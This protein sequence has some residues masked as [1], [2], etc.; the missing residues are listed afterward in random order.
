MVTLLISVVKGKD[1]ILS[2]KTIIK[3]AWISV[4]DEAR[5]TICCV[6]VPHPDIASVL[7]SLLVDVTAVQFVAVQFVG[8]TVCWLYSLLAVQLLAVQFVG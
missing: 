4:D 7:Y 6:V 3:V 2:F 8:C 5:S 1:H